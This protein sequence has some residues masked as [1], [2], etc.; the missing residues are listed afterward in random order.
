MQL[1]ETD[2]MIFQEPY[3][4]LPSLLDTELYSVFC[5]CLTE[6]GRRSKQKEHLS[7]DSKKC[8]Y[9]FVQALCVLSEIRH[10]S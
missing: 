8:S 5:D 3:S 2:C 9:S 7:D 10:A 6:V 1:R 4:S